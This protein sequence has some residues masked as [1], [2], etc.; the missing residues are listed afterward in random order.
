MQPIAKPGK[1]DYPGFGNKCNGCGLC[2][3]AEQCEMS[4]DFFGEQERCP[5]LKN[6]GP[7][8][9]CDLIWI[10]AGRPDARLWVNSKE[11]YDWGDARKLAH[12]LASQ[13]SD[14]RFQYGCDQNGYSFVVCWRRDR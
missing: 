12:Q 7:V 4:L 9:G 2:C 10:A 3:L 6:L 13:F 14:R 11:L 1:P 5:A 8:Y